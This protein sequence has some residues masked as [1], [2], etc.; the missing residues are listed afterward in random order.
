MTLPRLR[1]GIIGIGR[2]AAA[3]I[4][5]A[6][7]LADEVELVAFGA[8]DVERARPVAAEAGVER[9]YGDYGQLLADPQVDAVIVCLPQDMH[10]EVGVAAA[11]AGKHVLMEKPLTITAAEAEDVVQAAREAG[12]TLMVAQSRRFSEGARELVRQLP[13]IGPVFRTHIQFLVSFPAPPTNWWRSAARSGDLV[14]LLQGSHS[15]DSVLWWHGAVPRQVFATASR[16]DP[17]W[18]GYDEADVLCRFDGGSVA[19]VHLSLSTAPPLHEALVV[20]AQG[21][22]RLIERQTGVPFGLA[23]RL[24]RD[25][26]TVLE[27][28]A[29][30]AYATQLGEFAAAIREGR[31]PLASGAEIL[32]LMRVLDAARRSVA[33]GQPVDLQPDGSA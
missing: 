30:E 31:A 11:R 33:T 26:Q 2:I 14:I 4:A 3:H 8:R 5:A 28:P 15:L 7:R 32:P 19:S 22:L 24:E 6:K 12:V 23:Y 25:G 27:E 29:T 20:G 16:R 9:I 13:A 21:H 18:E 17:A 10:R 1:L